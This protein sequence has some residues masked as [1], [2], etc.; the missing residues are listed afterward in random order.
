MPP[1]PWPPQIFVRLGTKQRG[2]VTHVT[3][4]E[5]SRCPLERQDGTAETDETAETE[6]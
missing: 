5:H 3:F 1:L 6:P 2:L 4:F